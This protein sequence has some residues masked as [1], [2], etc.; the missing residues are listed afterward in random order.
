MRLSLL[1]ATL[2]LTL[3]QGSSYA[4]VDAGAMLTH[5]QTDWS[6]RH[7]SAPEGFPLEYYPRMR[8]TDDFSVQ[9]DSVV[10]QGNTRVP[11]A[12][13]QVALKKFIGKRVM[14]DRFAAINAA[15]TRAYRDAGHRAKVYI[16]EQTFGGGRLVVQVVEL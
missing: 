9:V 4:Q 5:T 2:V 14:V 10:I 16:P 8:W 11:T 7:A 1:S 6:A 3:S 15:V 13:L 12:R